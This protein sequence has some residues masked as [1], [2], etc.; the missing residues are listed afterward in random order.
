[1]ANQREI[2]IDVSAR[3]LRHLARGIYR[4]PAGAL[5]ELVSNAYDGGATEVTVN[6]GWPKFRKIVITDNGAGMTAS[7]FEWSMQHI[8]LSKKTIGEEIEIPGTNVKRAV[9]GHY[10]IGF[11][12]V[13]QVAAKLEIQ[14]KTK[15]DRKGFRAELDFEQ[16]DVKPADDD[17]PERARVKDEQIIE[18]REGALREPTFR[19]GKCTIYEETYGEKDKQAH[20]TRIVLK[21]IREEVVRKLTGQYGKP[22]PE[23]EKRARYSATYQ[24]LLAFLRENEPLSKQGLYP[25]EKLIWELGVYCPLPFTPLG[26]FRKGQALCEI[27]TK[28]AADRFS[29]V[30]DGMKVTKPYEEQFF[31]DTDYPIRHVFCWVD[32]PY[33]EEPDGPT[34]SCYLI[35]KARIRPKMLQGVLVRES[36][37]AVGMYD[38][39]YLE[40]PF[41]EGQKFNQLTGEIFAV[42][43][44]GALNIDRN[45][46]N[47]TDDRYLKLCEWFHRKLNKNV[48]SKIKKIQQGPE[49]TRRTENR[50][51]L[52]KV[53]AA[54]GKR[55]GK[56]VSL[57]FSAMGKEE[58]LVMRR[59]DR[60]IVNTDHPDG[61]G[62]S[63][64][65]EKL[66]LVIALILSGKILSEDIERIDR[67]VK[68]AKR[69][70]QK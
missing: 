38:T 34:A 45:S 55:L 20:F 50:D 26:L 52:R 62:S 58:S 7:E 65:Q 32:E 3:V 57:E 63:A 19:I 37:I 11:L 53:A 8:G 41:N 64:K 42:G 6:T 43:L 21:A 23:L 15:G 70:A 44:A 17:E 61:S 10:G 13:G 30:V 68:E 67:T 28:V 49:A 33:T 18:R 54:V 25:Y 39:T 22:N 36:G 5:K 24:E 56:R 47:Q 59:K 66:M 46:F 16:F 4:T 40:Y 51:F 9:I 35:Y 27:A 60:L 31:E 1:M 12:A 48:F 69:D 14:S 2:A 29:L